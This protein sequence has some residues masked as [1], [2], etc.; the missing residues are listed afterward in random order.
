MLFAVANP[1]ACVLQAIAEINDN[2][3]SA[4][5]GFQQFATEM[6]SQL[7]SNKI[8]VALLMV[9]LYLLFCLFRFI[10]AYP[11]AV[12]FGVIVIGLRTIPNMYSQRG[13]GG[14]GSNG[15]SNGSGNAS[16]DADSARQPP[17]LGSR[18]SFTLEDVSAST[19]NTFTYINTLM[20]KSLSSEKIAQFK[21]KLMGTA[22]ASS[23]T[24]ASPRKGKSSSDLHPQR[25]STA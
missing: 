10:T 13:P 9:V 18:P 6:V 12:G 8:V 14:N 4:S 5:Y 20:E 22:G 25:S 2:L 1:R 7:L 21:G 11:S 17:P 3:R 16:A 23:S 15:N 24:P 19:S